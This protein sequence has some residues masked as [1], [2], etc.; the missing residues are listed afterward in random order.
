MT[1]A[2]A[3]VLR[4]LLIELGAGTDPDANGAWPIFHSSEP[5]APDNC[6]TTYDTE[7]TDDG[8]SMP[9]GEAMGHDGFQVRVRSTTPKVGWAKASEIQDLLAETVYQDAVVVE[10]SN[11]LVQCAAKIGRVIPLGKDPT[12]KRSLFTLNATLSVKQ[13]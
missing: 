12:S 11:Y 2:P 4:W 6:I 9:T 7:G 13:L 5:G 10:G 8:R 1:H 3:D